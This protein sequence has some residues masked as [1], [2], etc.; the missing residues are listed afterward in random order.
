MRIDYGNNKKLE[1]LCTS[2]SEAKKKLPV[3]VAKKLLKTVN[4]IES[5]DNLEAI[6]KNS[7][8]HFHNLKGD[9]KG[10]YAIDIDGRLASYRMILKFDGYD[11]EQIF[12]IPKTIEVI[13]IKEVSNHYE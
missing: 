6:I 9:K 2:L 10:E 8:F 4:F 13:Q 11:N 7:P 5:A 3:K 12:G 1:E